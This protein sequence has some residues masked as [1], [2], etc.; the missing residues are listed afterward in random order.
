VLSG[1]LG[2]KTFEDKQRVPQNKR[3]YVQKLGETVLQ[4]IVFQVFSFWVEVFFFLPK[5][6]TRV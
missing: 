3:G 2:L 5:K 4:E 6:A 1:Y